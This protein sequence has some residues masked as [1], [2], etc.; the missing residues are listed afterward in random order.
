MK[1][2]IIGIG[3]SNEH[4]S[5]SNDDLSNIMDTSDEWIKAR[6][7]IENRQFASVNTSDLAYEASIAALK[8]ANITTREIDCLIVA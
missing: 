8:D 6:T 2:K 5:I 7:G 3:K 1:A 4:L